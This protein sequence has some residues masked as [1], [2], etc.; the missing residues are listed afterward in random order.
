MKIWKGV[1]LEGEDKGVVTLFVKGITIECRRVVDILKMHTDCKR[2]YL[3]GG[4][5]DVE[6]IFEC[7]AMSSYCSANSIDIIVETSVVGLS[8]MPEELFDDATQIITRIDEAMF[9]KLST[10]DLIKIDSGKDVHVIA[11]GNMIPTNLDTLN[12]D[13]FSTDVLI[14]DDEK[15]GY[16]K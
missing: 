10:T 1:E 7:A 13:M 2:V 16:V 9:D 8:K 14:Y 11:K 5:T 4:R 12:V 3:G 15:G 6:E